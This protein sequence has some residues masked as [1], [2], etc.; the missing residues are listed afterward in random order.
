MLHHPCSLVF[1]DFLHFVYI[2]KRRKNKFGLKKST[3]PDYLCW[4][5]GRQ[6]WD[7]EKQIDLHQTDCLPTILKDVGRSVFQRVVEK[8]KI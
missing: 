1:D 7:P 5:D 3:D 8:S 4:K 6:V 2:S